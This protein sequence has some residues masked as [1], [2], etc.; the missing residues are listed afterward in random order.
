MSRNMKYSEVRRIVHERCKGRCAICGDKISLEEMTIDHITPA[1][2]GGD[3]SFSNM[4]ATCDSCNCM[5]HYL[6]NDEFMRKLLKVTAH[7]FGKII[8][9]Y[10]KVGSL[11]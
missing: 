10:A 11:E 4:Q 3:W 7:N 8:K 1:Y 6:T 5:K 2:R 9:E